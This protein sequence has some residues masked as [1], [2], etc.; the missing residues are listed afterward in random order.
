MK[1]NNAVS[2]VD[3]IDPGFKFRWKDYDS[4][5]TGTYSKLPVS[6]FVKYDKDGYA[7]PSVWADLP[8]AAKAVLPVLVRMAYGNDFRQCW[9]NEDYLAGMTGIKSRKTVRGACDA[10][11]EFGLISMR[12]VTLKT[13]KRSKCYALT[14]NDEGHNFPMHTSIFEGGCW[15]ILGLQSVTAQA[16]YP[17]MRVFSRPNPALDPTCVDYDGEMRFDERDYFAYDRDE[18]ME[19]YRKRERDFCSADKD[20]LIEH[21]GICANSYKAAIKALIDSSFIAVSEINPEYWM[22][23]FMDGCK[24]TG[25]AKHLNSRLKIT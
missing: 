23:R 14:F 22:V 13:G 3:T 7:H 19:Y 8:H 9:P 12:K 20:V 15:F 17:V 5:F 25:G 10:L 2:A 6:L 24:N 1:K 11:Q 16:L 18:Y 4:K 21:A